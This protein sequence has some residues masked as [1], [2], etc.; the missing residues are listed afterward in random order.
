MGESKVSHHSVGV[1][2]P[3][4]AI[5]R[6]EVKGFGSDGREADFSGLV[7]TMEPD[8]CLSRQQP[9]KCS[10]AEIVDVITMASTEAAW[11]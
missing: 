5:R 10:T 3:T 2:A 8:T 11:H 7:R 6:V 9:G 1:A 4:P